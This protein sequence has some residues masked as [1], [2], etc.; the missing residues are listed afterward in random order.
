M[1]YHNTHGRKPGLFAYQKE[2]RFLTGLAMFA[3]FL[4]SVAGN[5]ALTLGARGGIYL[6]GGIVPRLGAAFDA[7]PFRERFVDKGRFR[8]YLEQI[9]T[10]VI[11][12]PAIGLL[13]AARALDAPSG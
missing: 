4:G 9:P 1:L 7:L 10:T 8:G 11:T 12:E 6:A 5:L 13:G 2:I 3:S